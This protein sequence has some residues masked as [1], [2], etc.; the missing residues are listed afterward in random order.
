[1][2]DNNFSNNHDHYKLDLFLYHFDTIHLQSIDAANKKIDRQNK[3][4]VQEKSR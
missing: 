3:R 2:V 1:M 4:K